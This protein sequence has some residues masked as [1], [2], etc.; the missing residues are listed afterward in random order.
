MDGAA[1]PPYSLQDPFGSAQPQQPEPPHLITAFNARIQ[2]PSSP[3]VGLIATRTPVPS[4]VLSR[5]SASRVAPRSDPTSHEL[6]QA[7][8]VSAAP[9]FELRTPLPARPRN[10][11][12][13]RMTIR[14]HTGPENMPFPQPVEQ[15]SSRGVDDQDV[16]I[17]V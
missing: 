6:V 16:S 7:G 14:P 9:Y 4:P 15:W 3:N 10:V 13:H 11:Y 12:Y 5:P 8:F 1:P 2:G 17:S